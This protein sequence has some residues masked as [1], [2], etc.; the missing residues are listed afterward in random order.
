MGGFVIL[1][2]D[3]KEIVYAGHCY[4]PGQTNNEVE[5][6]AMWDAVHCLQSLVNS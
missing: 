4:G 6:F 2:G 3:D 1:D 5:N